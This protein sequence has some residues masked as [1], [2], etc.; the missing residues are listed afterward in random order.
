[1]LNIIIAGHSES[2][3]HLCDKN[4]IYTRSSSE[5]SFRVHSFLKDHNRASSK[6]KKLQG[7]TNAA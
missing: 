4:K 1:M 2:T 3:E 5:S 7:A 6:K